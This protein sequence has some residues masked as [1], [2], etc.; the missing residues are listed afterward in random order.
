MT[1]T[2]HD[3]NVSTLLPMNTRIKQLFL[4]T[5]ISLAL[6][7]KMGLAAGGQSKT[8]LLAARAG[9][10]GRRFTRTD[11]YV[12]RSQLDRQPRW[13]GMS[14]NAPLSVEK[15]CTIAVADVKKRFPAVGNWLVETVAL[16]NLVIGGEGDNT[17]S[18]PGVWCYEVTFV[19][20][21]AATR[22][23]FDTEVGDQPLTRVVLLD[24]T[25][26]PSRAQPGGENGFRIERK[27][28]T[29]P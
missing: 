15:A 1:M 19:P 12:A 21:D 9:Y 18:Y 4:T 6:F 14:T 23:K 2:R 27:E 13:D 26:V 10:S 24:G 29:K 8:V 28:A 7:P 11:W 16:R 25:L 22:K 5:C 3:P 17:Y 20:A